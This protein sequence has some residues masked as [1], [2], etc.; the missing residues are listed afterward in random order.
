MGLEQFQLLSR[1]RDTLLLLAAKQLNGGE[2]LVGHAKDAD[3]AI[4]GKNRFDSLNMHLGILLT[5]TMAH[6]DGELKHREAVTLQILAKVSIGLAISFRLGR[7]I[8]KHQYPHNSIF[9]E[10]IH[11]ALLIRRY[12]LG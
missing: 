2:L 5:G 12:R 7:Q 4:V 6:V 10:T 11:T 8:E 1:R 9:T 3:I